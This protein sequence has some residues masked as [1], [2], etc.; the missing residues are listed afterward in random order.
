MTAKTQNSKTVQ[1]QLV[2]VIA[3]FYAGSVDKEATFDKVAELKMQDKGLPIHFSTMEAD[4]KTIAL[5]E[6]IILSDEDLQKKVSETMTGKNAPSSFY[7]VS[8][9]AKSLLGSVPQVGSF[10]EAAKFVQDELKTNFKENPHHKA[11]VR[12]IGQNAKA[13]ITRYILENPNCSDED[14][15][16]VETD[17]ADKSKPYHNLAISYRELFSSLE[18]A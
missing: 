5:A 8:E 3:A 16:N 17:E 7:G 13:M 11:V 4:I 1:A 15:L 10:D 12:G 2:A 6:G 9:L 14:I 18:V